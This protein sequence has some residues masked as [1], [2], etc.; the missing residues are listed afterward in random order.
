M[1]KLTRDQQFQKSFEGFF[2]NLTE[3]FPELIEYKLTSTTE[4]KTSCD[5]SYT[6]HIP[7]NIVAFHL[8]LSVIDGDGTMIGPG[9][10]FK[11]Q[12]IP[13]KSEFKRHY[14]N[15]F[16]D[17]E[18]V[19]GKIIVSYT[20]IYDY[21][22]EKE[23]DRIISQE[24]RNGVI[25]SD[26][27]EFDVFMKI[28]VVYHKSH[29]PFPVPLTNEEKLEK[30]CRQLEARN[31]ELVLNLN[32]LTNMYQER[33][34]QY[35][36]LRRRMRVERRNIENKYKAMFEKMQK[37]FADYYSEIKVKDDCPVCYEVITAEKLK[38]PGCCHTICSCCAEKCD[39]C[40]IC[41][42]SY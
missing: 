16:K 28:L 18:L 24:I 13:T 34:E 4:N 38:V 14:H 9:P 23:D 25:S 22:Y 15:Y 11:K 40:P 8:D 35:Q 10:V 17:F 7:R 33:D 3:T 5:H 39:K 37:K 1:P 29:F 20:E 36:Y 12:Q 30:R 42:E 19:S 31:Q 2:E 6:L 21:W 26:L 32:G 27:S 41:R